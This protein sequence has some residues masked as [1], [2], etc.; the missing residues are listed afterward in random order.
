MCL[1]VSR[2]GLQSTELRGYSCG[3]SAVRG[4]GLALVPG[5]PRGVLRHDRSPCGGTPGPAGGAR[6]APRG[7]G[8]VRLCAEGPSGGVEGSDA[9]VSGAVTSNQASAGWD[10][11]V[12]H[13]WATGTEVVTPGA[14]SDALQ[15]SWLVVQ[16]CRPCCWSCPQRDQWVASRLVSNMVRVWGSTWKRGQGKEAWCCSPGAVPLSAGE[17][18]SPMPVDSRALQLAGLTLFCDRHGPAVYLGQIGQFAGVSYPPAP[19]SVPR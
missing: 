16:L 5:Y 3:G 4:L 15:S 8:A 14:R 1:R 7:T 18:L 12:R 17:L 2:G 11:F 19:V 6:A 13:V 9:P 10:L